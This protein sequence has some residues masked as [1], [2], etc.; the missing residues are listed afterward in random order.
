MTHK[1]CVL[2]HSVVGLLLLATTIEDKHIATVLPNHV[3]DI[4]RVN[5]LPLIICA[6]VLRQLLAGGRPYITALAGKGVL[7]AHAALVQQ[8]QELPWEPVLSTFSSRCH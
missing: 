7:V 3:P 6:L 8:F 4:T 2:V 1:L 5:P